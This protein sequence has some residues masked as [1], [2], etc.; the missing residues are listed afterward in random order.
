[1][2]E[3][4]Y[5]FLERSCCALAWTAQKLRHYLLSHTTHLISRSDPLKYLLGKPMPTGRMEKWQMIFSEF[6]IIFTM[7]K[8]IKGQVVAD[9]LAEN[10]MEDDYQPLHTYFP[11]EEILFIGTSENMNEQCLEWRF[12]FDGA[13]NSFGAG[14]RAVLVSSE[15]NHF[16]VATKLRFPCTNNMA[17]YETCIFGLKI[18]LKMEIKDLIAFSDSDLLVHQTLK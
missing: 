14:I 1:M 12:F 4:N 5:S 13:S 18:A 16:P 6:D 15:G 7:Q 8:A 3:A 17:E 9:H 2:Y 10:P 11:D